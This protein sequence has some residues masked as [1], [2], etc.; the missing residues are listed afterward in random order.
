MHPDYHEENV[1]NDIALLQISSNEADDIFVDFNMGY[2][3]P[4]RRERRPSMSSFSP[5]CLPAQD[6]ELPVNAQ[7][8]I[9]G[10]GKEKKSHRY[11]TDVLHEAEVSYFSNLK[12]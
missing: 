1:D 7:C 9:V 8:T 2:K 12:I 11:G 3:K 6:E 4:D 5:A 10:W